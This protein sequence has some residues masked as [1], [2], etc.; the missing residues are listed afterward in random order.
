MRYLIAA[1]LLTT[2]AQAG[3]VDPWQR[4]YLLA[5]RNSGGTYSLPNPA[6]VTGSSISSTWANSTLNDL[7]T[8]IT[9]SLDRA[10]RGAMTGPL[11]LKSGAS[12]AAPDLAWDVETN[13]GWYRAAAGDLR[14]ALAG[15]DQWKFTS[16]T[17]TMP[18]TTPI[19]LQH[20][21]LGSL[22]GMWL[23]TASPTITNYALVGDTTNT[24]VNAPSGGTGH[25]RVNNVDIATWNG[26][27]MAL[28]ATST[29]ALTVGASGTAISNSIRGTLTLGAFILSVAPASCSQ[30]VVTV[31]GAVL[32]ADC[33]AAVNPN[34]VVLS[35]ATF[36]AL[37]Q[38]ACLVR[39]ANTC[40]VNLCNGD[41]VNAASDNVGVAGA[42]VS[43]RVFNP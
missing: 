36:S 14:F 37:T 41:P 4:K 26:S 21:V 12:A 6:V 23:A 18:G 40:V 2:A 3:N 20:D 30:Y 24:F 27:S 11:R 15:A 38:A 33:A 32:G 25:L 22:S 16:L 39:A 10:G 34:S 35:P 8:E 5:S 17:A 31:T 7:A 9:N 1:L 43:C 19:I 13:S 28:P 29:G 42:V